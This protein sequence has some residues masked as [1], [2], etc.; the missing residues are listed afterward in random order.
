M[1]TLTLTQKSAASYLTP[2]RRKKR[3]ESID[4]MRGAVMIIMALDHTRH[5]FHQDAFV[6]E[7]TDLS[8]T[9]IFLFF[10]R[11]ITHYC[12]PVF[13]FLAGMS[14]FLSGVK[15]S[16]R[17]LA[18]YLISRGLWLIFVELVIITLGQT[19]NPGLPYFNLQVIWAIGVSMIILAGLIFL[20]RLWILAIALLLIE[21]HNLLDNFH[22][23]G[24]GPNAFIWSVLH[25]PNK[26]VWGNKTVFVMYPV[27]PW[28]G[29]MALGYCMGTLYHSRFDPEKRKKLL[30]YI[31]SAAII[32]F[33]ILRAFNIYGD[34]V[35][36]SVQRN[37]AFSFLSILNVTK[38]PPSLLYTLITLGPAMVLLALLDGH[39][40]NSFTR[41]IAVF[42]R[43][44]FFYYIIHIYLLHLCA[45][46]G[47]I[48]SDYNWY[49][50]ILTTKLNLTPALKGYGF[51]LFST[52]CIWIGLI[53]FLYPFCKWFD[54]YKRNNQSTQWWLTYL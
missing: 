19:F 39:P 15:K 46:V 23:I 25:E 8:H 35:N 24:T 36:W 33:F 38:Y 7:P 4:F 16:K 27:L 1:S 37:A 50:M 48:I 17:E 30:L 26:F 28:I 10:T 3:I 6:Y 14:A 31:G 47:A 18:F 13:V 42:G 45:M 5:F 51:N 21:G 41:R 11:F 20:K 32:L 49:D 12:A 9:T 29:I 43:V 52:Y 54:H 53:L 34:P 40:L 22:V 44:P 2:V